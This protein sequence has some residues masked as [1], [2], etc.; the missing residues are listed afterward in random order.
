MSLKCTPSEAYIHAYD[1]G[2]AHIP[3]LILPSGRRLGKT[4]NTQY[5]VSMPVRKSKKKI[6]QL[7]SILNS[8]SPHRYTWDVSDWKNRS[9]TVYNMH[10]PKSKIYTDIREFHRT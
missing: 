8:I 6:S 7:N 3:E 5:N 10:S 2:L 1:N 4:R 9:G